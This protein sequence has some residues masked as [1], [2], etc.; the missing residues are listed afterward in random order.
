VTATSGNLTDIPLIESCSWFYMQAN[1]TYGPV[2][3]TELRA[4]ARLRFFG[5]Q[6]LVRRADSPRWRLASHVDGL[7]PDPAI[8]QAEVTE[9]LPGGSSN[10][11]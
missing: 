6:D 8:T 11:H 1:K 5:P 7:F 2:S 9:R 4:A 3:A 10:D